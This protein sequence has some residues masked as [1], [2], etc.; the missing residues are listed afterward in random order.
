MT[1][2]Q[3]NLIAFRPGFTKNIFSSFSYGVNFLEQSQRVVVSAD[4]LPFVK[5]K[6]ILKTNIVLLVASAVFY[7]Y[8]SGSIAS[9]NVEIIQKSNFLERASGEFDKTQ[10]SLLSA[11]SG[12]NTGLF[13]KM[14]FIETDNLNVIKRSNNVATKEAYSPY[15]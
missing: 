9:G 14:G 12:F 7:V 2:F 8:L 13:E 6:A 1:T 10:A 3:K 5:R 4:S 15:Q 11:N